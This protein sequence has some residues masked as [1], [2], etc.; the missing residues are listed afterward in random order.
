MLGIPRGLCYLQQLPI[1]GLK[2]LKNSCAQLCKPKC[3][4]LLLN[5]ACVRVQALQCL[6]STL[7]SLV[8]WFILCTPVAAANDAPSAPDS[9]L[10]PD[11]GKLTSSTVEATEEADGQP[12][13]EGEV[14]MP[15]RI[16]AEHS[17][18]SSH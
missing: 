13:G 9:S 14:P 12:E 18:W 15:G 10:R 3:D 7:R 6:V 17:R 5:L 11:W 4:R 16:W 8:E 2:V 1:C